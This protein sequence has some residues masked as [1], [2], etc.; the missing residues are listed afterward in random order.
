M[1]N[2]IPHSF[3]ASYIYEIPVGHGRKVAPENAVVDAV[4]GGWQIA[5]VTSLK[6]GF[7]LSITAATNNTNSFGGNQ[8]PNLVGDPTLDNPTIERWFNT[9]AFAQ[10][11]A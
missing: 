9:N 7:P 5:G 6:S 2:D 3:V 1:N 10:P 4:V 11:P 8:R